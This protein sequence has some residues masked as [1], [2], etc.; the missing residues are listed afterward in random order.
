M[1]TYYVPDGLGSNTAVNKTDTLLEFIKL[2]SHLG[3]DII[4]ST[5]TNKCII[6]NLKTTNKQGEIKET[7]SAASLC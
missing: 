4:P 2:M 7:S 3:R 6:T 5:Q 1:T